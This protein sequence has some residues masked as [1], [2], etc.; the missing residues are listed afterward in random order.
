MDPQ[1]QQLYTQGNHLLAMKRLTEALEH[2]SAAV[3]RQ[4][5]FALAN[6][7]PSYCDNPVGPPGFASTA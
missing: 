6:S 3:A 1:V 5:G 4:P 2:F 7:A